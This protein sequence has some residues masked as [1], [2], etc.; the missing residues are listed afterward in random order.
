MK[1]RSDIMD[2]EGTFGEDF[3][4]LG[5]PHKANHWSCNWNSAGHKGMAGYTE[6]DERKKLTT[7]ITVSSK[8]LIQ[9]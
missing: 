2:L 8:D 9:F 3:H 6:D 7:K 4:K 5:D 1:Q